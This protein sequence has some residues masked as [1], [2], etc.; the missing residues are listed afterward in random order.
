MRSW[1]GPA[2][3]VGIALMASCASRPP[4]MEG[5]MTATPA[6][7]PDVQGRA[8]PIVIRVYELR[9]PGAFSSADF[10]S[11]FDKEAETLSADL[12]GREE[13]SLRPAESRP[14]KRQLQADTKFIGVAA[15]FRDLEN[16]RW[17]QVAPVP[18][19]RGVTLA[20]GIEARA[21]TLSVK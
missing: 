13:F 8:S 3:V 17:R 20:I 16:A 10:F 21:V 15:A 4:M 14:Y 12:V 19:K 5:A 2:L 9:S 7:N 18:A 1:R 6:A 11:I